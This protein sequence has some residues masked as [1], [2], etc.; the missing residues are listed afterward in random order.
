MRALKKAITT[1]TRELRE[2]IAC[3]MVCFGLVARNQAMLPVEW[4]SSSPTKGEKSPP[5]D[6]YSKQGDI[7][8][9]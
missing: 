7:R 6:T 3:A 8:E 2:G 9:W 4:M 5:E 1:E